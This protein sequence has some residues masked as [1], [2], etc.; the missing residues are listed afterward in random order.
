MT[1]GRPRCMWGWSMRRCVGCGWGWEWF[2][3]AIVH[4][5]RSGSAAE[6][7]DPATAR[8]DAGLG[9][10]V[11]AGTCVHAPWAVPGG[12]PHTPACWPMADHPFSEPALHAPQTEVRLRA[13][14][15]SQPPPP[16][17]VTRTPL[18][19]QKRQ[20]GASR[21]IPPSDCWSGPQMPSPPLLL[22]PELC[23]PPK[24]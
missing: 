15:P 23:Q 1:R 19:A 14:C 6:R 4:S 24:S 17:L 8:C 7:V 16:S 10:G 2:R 13:E 18:G 22:V 5:R 12:D 21:E 9:N 20:P 3:W 11:C